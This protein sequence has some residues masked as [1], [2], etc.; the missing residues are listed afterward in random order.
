[1]KAAVHTPHGRLSS[2]AT[3]LTE[4]VSVSMMVS[5]VLLLRD[6]ANDDVHVVRAMK[7]WWPRSTFDG[8]T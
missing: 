5:R 4:I 6:C 2:E 3:C 8:R 7:A 1:M